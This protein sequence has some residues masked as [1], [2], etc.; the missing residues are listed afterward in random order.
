MYQD[1]FDFKGT[2]E[3][4]AGSPEASTVERVPFAEKSVDKPVSPPNAVGMPAVALAESESV[5]KTCCARCEQIQVS[6]LGGEQSPVPEYTRI[7]V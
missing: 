2:G 4:D 1:Y 6:P 7:P 5:H 3:S